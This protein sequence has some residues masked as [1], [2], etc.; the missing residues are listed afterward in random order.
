MGPTDALPPPFEPHRAV[1]PVTRRG[2]ELPVEMV[3]EP[4]GEAVD[5]SPCHLPLVD[6]L[7]R[8]DL[9]RRRVFGD[10]AVHEGLRELG[11]VA[12][13]VAQAAVAEHVD[14]DVRPKFWRYS[15]AMRATVTTASGSSPLTWKIGASTPFAKSEGYG[16]ER[17]NDGLVVK[18]IWLLTM[19][20]TVPPV[21]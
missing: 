3:A 21:L 4:V 18:P 5:L 9:P 19:T 10:L 20:W 8:V 15:V 17:E 11:F 16:E 12:L 14:D 7:A 2:L 13:V 1:G 6:E